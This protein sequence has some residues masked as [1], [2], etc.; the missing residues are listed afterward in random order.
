MPEEV[1][2]DVARELLKRLMVASGFD[3]DPA[4][5]VR[6]FKA[7]RA[8]NKTFRDV[9]DED[10]LFGVLRPL[11]VHDVAAQWHCQAQGGH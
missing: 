8:V 9:F 3:K 11:P 7:F 10:H 6:A 2:G 5:V 4:A 1:C